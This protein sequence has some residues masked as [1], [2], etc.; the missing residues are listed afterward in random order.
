MANFNNEAVWED[1]H[2]NTPGRIMKQTL[3][4]RCFMYL[5]IDRPT[6]DDDVHKIK[7]QSRERWRHVLGDCVHSK[8]PNH[9]RLEATNSDESVDCYNVVVFSNLPLYNNVPSVPRNSCDVKSAKSLQQC[10][11]LGRHLVSSSH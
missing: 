10:S 2:T 6:T 9:D 1:R 7:T 8:F 5:L 4:T 11:S 3:R